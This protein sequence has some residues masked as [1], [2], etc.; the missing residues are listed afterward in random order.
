MSSVQY[1][2]PPLVK[3]SKT[4]NNNSSSFSREAFSDPVVTTEK[5]PKEMCVGWHIDAV[6]NLYLHSNF[7]SPR[8]YI[9]DH[10]ERATE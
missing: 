6:C 10:K 2:A 3:V 5:A 9:Q 8:L 4:A 7:C 1:L